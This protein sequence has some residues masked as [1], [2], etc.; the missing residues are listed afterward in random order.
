MTNNRNTTHLSL[1]SNDWGKTLTKLTKPAQTGQIPKSHKLRRNNGWKACL[2][3]EDNNKHGG[4]GRV[5]HETTE[6]KFGAQIEMWEGDGFHEPLGCSPRQCA[7]R[8]REW[9]MGPD[10][11]DNGGHDQGGSARHN[12]GR[13]RTGDERGGREI[14]NS[15]S[16]SLNLILVC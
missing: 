12:S 2:S 15:L 13:D 4:S 7:S 10:S 5:L 16:L 8:N 1:K 11:M 14:L 3:S 9:E 6:S